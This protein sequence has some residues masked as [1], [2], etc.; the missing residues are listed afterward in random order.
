MRANYQSHALFIP[1]YLVLSIP[2]T[3][4]TI[5]TINACAPQHLWLSYL[6]VRE[7][8]P[9]HPVSQAVRSKK[10]V[11][12]TGVATCAYLTTESVVEHMW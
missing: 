9:Y 12:G 3:L 6:V 10:V 4:R 7:Y 1:Y 2:P 8:Y 5:V 11:R